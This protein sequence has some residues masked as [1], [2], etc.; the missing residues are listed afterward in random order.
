MIWTSDSTGVLVCTT[1]GMFLVLVCTTVG[2]FLMLSSMCIP[3]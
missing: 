3:A 1:V 2:M